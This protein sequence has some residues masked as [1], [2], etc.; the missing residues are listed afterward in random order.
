[1]SF[2]NHF[3]LELDNFN[4]PISLSK[5][6]FTGTSIEDTV[7]LKVNN[8]FKKEMKLED[9]SNHNF[10]TIHENTFIENEVWFKSIDL[11]IQRKEISLETIIKNKKYKIFSKLID[12]D[13]FLCTYILIS[14]QEKKSEHYTSAI[15][16]E[17]V[18]LSEI[19]IWEWDLESNKII[20][21]DIWRKQLGY[22]DQDIIEIDSWEKLVHPDDLNYTFT[23]I[24]KFLSDSEVHLDIEF[25]IK[26]KNGKY[27]WIQSK[28][29][30]LYRDNEKP[31]Y[32]LGTQR[33]ISRKKNNEL[34]LEKI[35]K[36]FDKAG[37]ITGIGAWE[38]DLETMTPF[39]SKQTYKIHEVEETFQ[40][41]LSTAIHFYAPDSRKIIQ[42]VIE[43]A[44]EKGTSWDL[45]LPFIT[46]K[47]RKLL[48]RSIGM[49]EFKDGK[50]I[51]LMGVF[52]DITETRE[53]EKE[54][55]IKNEEYNQLF[56]NSLDMIAIAGTDGM[57]KIINPEWSKTLGY[58]T[59]E[60]LSQPW[61]DFVHPED[62]ERTIDAGNQLNEQKKVIN[63]SNR[64]KT[65]NNEYI[66]LDW[67]CFPLGDK[68]YA[69]ARN[70]TE[71]KNM[72]KEIL[73]AKE[74][75]LK[76]S[77]AKSEF[78]ANMSHEIR[79]PL[80]SV[81]GFS[82]IL[83]DMN[84]DKEL[85]SIVQSINTSALSLM[86]IVNDILDFS[87]IETGKLEL[88]QKEN[89]LID[90]LSDVFSIVRYSVIEKGL[91]FIQE[92]DKSLPDKIL[93]DEIKLKQVLI[94]LLNN[95]VKFTSKGKIIFK[96]EADP[97]DLTHT[98]LNFSIEDTGIGVNRNFI[99]KIFEG[100]SQAD[101]SITRKYGGT[102]L[103]LSISS[104]IVKLLGGN[105]KVDSKEGIGSK[106][107][108]KIKV[109][110]IK[111]EVNQFKKVN[112]NFKLINPNSKILIL[113]DV[114]LNLTLLDKMIKKIS[115]QVNIFLADDSIK[116]VEIYENEKPN[117]VILDLQMPVDDGYEV[118]KKLKQV[119]EK[120]SIKTNFIALSANALKEEKAR[121]LK[122]GF[123]DYYSKPIELVKLRELLDKYLT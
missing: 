53:K 82:E 76:A 44:I 79:T 38:I 63:F 51:R 27:I 122:E 117:L 24:R 25:R 111:T 107:Y 105:L 46:A 112:S 45:E 36:L 31:I 34:N 74:E 95:A 49:P 102:G 4:Y 39:W 72:E 67:N 14:N 78:L 70:I 37:E 85:D 103:G 18:E 30:A 3:S 109:R 114:Y 97:I 1:M 100:F 2:Q 29:K 17:V 115:K 101:N 47:N 10:K 9:P 48:V 94:N 90:I 110:V 62:I 86:G 32:I 21:S 20:L 54:L 7:Y 43:L 8:E 35:N 104:S 59:E 123:D 113:D 6:I 61:L 84:K 50:A 52:I 80:N 57:F 116:A 55:R 40:P 58:T 81:I 118:L 93:I 65:K 87:K 69:I 28:A 75:A 120:L 15:L 56:N 96:L 23:S 19:G 64:Y 66:W 121:S 13:S 89:N 22:T 60:I 16:K 108:F 33:D 73:E 5:I 71:A 12:D 83:K 106:F 42:E 91:E 88:D 11:L 26:Q 119:S 41:D 98:Y 68:I 92:I 99:S 77:K